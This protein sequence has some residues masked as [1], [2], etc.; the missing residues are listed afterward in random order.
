MWNLE[1]DGELHTVEGGPS[2]AVCRELNR[3]AARCE[4]RQRQVGLHHVVVRAEGGRRKLTQQHSETAQEPHRHRGAP[5]RSGRHRDPQHEVFGTAE[6]SRRHR[7][8]VDSAADDG[9]EFDRGAGAVHSRRPECERSREAAN[10]KV[11]DVVISL[12]P[13]AS[14]TSICT[15]RTPGAASNV[16]CDA[17]ALTTT[18]SRP[19]GPDAPSNTGVPSIFITFIKTLAGAAATTRSPGTRGAASQ[20]NS[21]RVRPSPEVD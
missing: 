10:H 16:S 5:S 13:A 1:R 18:A 2:G 7:R 3:V 21:T 20:T 4:S 9:A 14:S 11:A 12:R 6:L 17:P 15:S 8:H 19:A